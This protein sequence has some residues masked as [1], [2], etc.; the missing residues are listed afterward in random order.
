MADQCC[1]NSSKPMCQLDFTQF[2]NLDKLKS[3]LLDTRDLKTHVPDSE[4]YQEAIYNC[5]DA[6]YMMKTALTGMDSIMSYLVQIRKLCI[7]AANFN[8]NNQ[9]SQ[10]V[11]N[12]NAT[13][14]TNGTTGN[15]STHD[16]QN[17]Y[18][19]VQRQYHQAM[20]SQYLNQINM[21]AMNTEWNQNELLS[22]TTHTYQIGMENNAESEFQIAF[23]NLHSG[24]KTVNDTSDSDAAERALDADNDYWNAGDGDEDMVE[25]QTSVLKLR[26]NDTKQFRDI[27]AGGTAGNGAETG[28]INL[29][30]HSEAQG[31]LDIVDGAIERLNREVAN[32]LAGITRVCAQKEYLQKLLDNVYDEVI[33]A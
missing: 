6:F 20:L 23:G 16:N 7:R 14:Q 17:D 10:H 9:A 11:H 15:A 27:S 32:C 21:V 12:G 24:V 33:R 19:S 3:N 26:W 30:N 13:P 5:E 18:N 8:D 28:G 25:G 2:P 22:G 4:S 29:R 1:K 31:A